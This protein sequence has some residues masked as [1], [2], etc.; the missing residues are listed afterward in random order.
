MTAHDGS[1]NAQR[2]NTPLAASTQSPFDAMKPVLDEQ[3]PSVKM[4]GVLT[5]IFLM[6]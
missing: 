6:R 4:M 2:A 1:W 5:W 3:V